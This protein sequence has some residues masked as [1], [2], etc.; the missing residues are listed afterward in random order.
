MYSVGRRLDRRGWRQQ[1]MN[2]GGREAM[3]LGWLGQAINA[4]LLFPPVAQHARRG[5]ARRRAL[6]LTQRA[7]GRERRRVAGA[8][9]LVYRSLLA[10]SR[11]RRATRSPIHSASAVAPLDACTA[12]DRRGIATVSWSAT[13]RS[14]GEPRLYAKRLTRSA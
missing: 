9:T 13:T 6:G 4:L 1:H 2:A 11:S 12:S 10:S 5:A 3:P 7:D 8:A 14:L